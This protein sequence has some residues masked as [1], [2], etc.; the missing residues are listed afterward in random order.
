[1]A[2]VQYKFPDNI[3]DIL[4]CGDIEANGLLEDKREWKGGQLIVHKKVDRVWMACYKIPEAGGACYDFID[5]EMLK[6]HKRAL[7]Q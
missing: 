5:D 7:L 4:V 1:M 6:L 3:K 2:E